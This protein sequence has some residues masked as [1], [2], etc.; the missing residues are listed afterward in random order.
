[1]RS[2][3]RDYYKVLQVDA[4]AD[5]EVI[6]A[7]YRVLAAR[8]HPEND[9]T[10]VHEI[11]LAEIHRAYIA[12][13]DPGRRRAYDIERMDRVSPIGPGGEVALSIGETD[14]DDAPANRSLGARVSALL[15]EGAGGSPPGAT[16][17]DFGRYAGWS[18]RDI[19]N[20]DPDY[21]RWLTRH[22]SGIRFRG[23]IRRLLKDESE[24]YVP[25]PASR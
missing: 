11:R 9:L 8:F 1:M 14:V 13:I 16:Q 19:A 3:E 12:L 2:A 18:L 23:E 25:P 22:S 4:E 20:E 15:Q 24:S 6:E 5:A 7:A 17:L 21:L 10:G